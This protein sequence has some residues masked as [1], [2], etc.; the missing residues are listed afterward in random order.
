MDSIGNDEYIEAISIEI[1]RASRNLVG[2]ET[3]VPYG[4]CSIGRVLSIFA[5]LV[6]VAKS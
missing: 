6:S 5:S 4:I 2:I 1:S 3:G